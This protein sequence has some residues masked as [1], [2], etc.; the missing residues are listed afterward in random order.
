[1][2]GDHKTRSRVGP[3]FEC[4]A[5]G[6]KLDRQLNAG[7]NVG[8]TALRETVELGGLRLGLDALSEDAMRP[9][10]PFDGVNGARAERRERE[11]STVR[12]PVRPGVGLNPKAAQGERR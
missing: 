3:T 6:W 9:R 2:W 11:G 4:G 7:V 12:S 8:R 1:M 10:Y 5:C